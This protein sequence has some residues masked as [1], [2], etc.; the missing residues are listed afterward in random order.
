MLFINA[1]CKAET[2]KEQHKQLKR[3]KL[4]GLKIVPPTRS[5]YADV[6]VSLQVLFVLYKFL[7]LVGSDQD[8]PLHSVLES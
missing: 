6:A 5:S 2:C 7:T 1:C 3:W 8:S 4:F